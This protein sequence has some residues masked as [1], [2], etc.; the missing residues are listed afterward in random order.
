MSFINEF[1]YNVKVNFGYNSLSIYK[2]KIIII[3]INFI[4]NKI[5]FLKNMLL[6]Q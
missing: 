5:Y 4:I 1:I 2:I 6:Y 3:I